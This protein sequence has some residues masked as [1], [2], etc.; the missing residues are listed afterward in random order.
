MITV[1]KVDLVLQGFILGTALLALLLDTGY[2]YFI[3]P[4]LG[5]WQLISALSNTYSMN[6]QGNG[7]R[8]RIIIYWILAITALLSLWASSAG[9]VA[10]FIITHLCWGIAIYYWII[11]LL[12]IQNLQYRRELSTVIRK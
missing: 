12:F 10:F 11:Y 4:V 9:D 8:R 2:L 5:I 7:Y 1:R 6:H 3:E